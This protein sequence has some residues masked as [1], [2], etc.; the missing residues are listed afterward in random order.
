MRV[1][2]VFIL[3]SSAALAADTE[4]TESAEDTRAEPQ[5]SKAGLVG[6]VSE[7]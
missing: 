2:A 6:E 3:A 7:F 4:G 5:M 1:S